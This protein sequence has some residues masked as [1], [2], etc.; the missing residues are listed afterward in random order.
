MFWRMSPKRPPSVCGADFDGFT[1]RDM[2]LLKR[3]GA[4]LGRIEDEQPPPPKI[5][6]TRTAPPAT[7]PS[8]A[9]R[10]DTPTPDEPPVEGERAEPVRKRTVNPDS[11]RV[12]D[13]RALESVRTR[14]KGVGYCVEDGDRRKFG[15]RE[16]LLIPDPGNAFDPK[17]VAVY[18]KGR[19]VGYLSASR[20]GMLSPILQ[21]MDADAFKVSGTGTSSNSIMLWVDAPKVEALRKFART[22]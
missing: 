12:V 9:R 17:A 13:L 3:I 22:S 10:A 19:M 14:I 16:Y 5:P 21:Q 7:S 20:A 15:G 4:A 1:L 8:V 11:L 6:V 18:G 2:D